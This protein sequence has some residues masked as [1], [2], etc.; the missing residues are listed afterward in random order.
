MGLG[1]HPFSPPGRPPHLHSGSTPPVLHPEPSSP[2]ANLTVSP[3]ALGSSMAPY[4]L[5]DKI[6]RPVQS[7]KT[8]TRLSSL[9]S[10]HS[11]SPAFSRSHQFELREVSR[12][13][14]VTKLF[15]MLFPPPKMPSPSCPTRQTLKD[16]FQVSAQMIASSGPTPPTGTPWAN[17]GVPLQ[18]SP[19][20]VHEGQLATLQGFDESVSLQDGKLQEARTESF[21]L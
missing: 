15:P 14:H 18:D 3:F 16:F 4:C 5:H 10:Q 2:N 1:P 9:I 12:I 20:P 19:H 13:C 11:Y 21:F 6:Y 7:T 17:V 8:P